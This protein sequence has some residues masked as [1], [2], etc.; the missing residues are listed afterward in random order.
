MQ[1]AGFTAK[2]LGPESPESIAEARK[3]AD[4]WDAARMDASPPSRYPA[5]S[6]G[7]FYEAFRRTEKWKTK[8]L[9][10]REDYER[11]WKH[12]AAWSPA[13]GRPTLALTACVAITP[14]HCDAFAAHLSR[15]LSPA[16]RFRAVKCLKALLSN[17]VVRLRLGYASPA[18]KLTNPQAK[19]R[20]AIWLGAQIEDMAAGA[21]I[22]GF[23]GMAYGIWLAWETMLSPVDVRT[24]RP[25]QL[26]HDGQGWF[27]QGSRGKTGKETFAAL[28]DDLGAMLATYLKAQHRKEADNSPIIRQRDGLPYRTK[29]TFAGDFRDVRSFM[30][31]GDTRQLLD[32]RRSANVEADAAGADKKTMGELLANG[33]ADSRFLEETYT[34]PTVAKAREVAAQRVQGRAKLAGEVMKGEEPMSRITFTTKSDGDA[35]VRGPERALAGIICMNMLTGQLDLSDFR[36]AQLFPDGHYL[37]TLARERDFPAGPVFSTRLKTA[38]SAGDDTLTLPDG[39][40]AC[41]FDLSLNTAIVLGE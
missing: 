4:A 15:T 35:E 34:P 26:R 20:S 23:D 25:S 10:T 6:F 40:H 39:R 1:A 5:G 27:V 17:M 22:A 13:K 16:E 8:S 31:P 36:L 3:L 7:D 9:R 32:I 14:D 41:A 28:S 29:D 24:L 38:L 30:F 21:A 12:I 37:R 33:L 2:A 11:A 19:G 18:T